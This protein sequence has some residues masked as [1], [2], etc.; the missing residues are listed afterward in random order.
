[1]EG[2]SSVSIVLVEPTHPGNIGAAARAM[3]NM[4]LTRLRLVRPAAF[5]S[6]EATALAAGARDVLAATTVHDDL[7]SALAGT[8]WVIATTARPRERSVPAR[9]MELACREAI[10]QATNGREVAVVFGREAHG[11]SNAEL[12]RCDLLTHI[13]TA[14]DFSSLNLA[15]AVQVLAYELCRQARQAGD[16]PAS[17]TV[18][19][20]LPAGGEVARGLAQH[21]EQVVR[22][23]GYENPQAPERTHRRLRSLLSR[24]R[25]TESDVQFLR[26]L[27]AAVQKAVRLRR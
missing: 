21:L 26:G 1:M 10:G 15:Q 13:P 25:P 27:L 9:D 20:E 17:D 24:M 4:G 5:P 7:E 23:V 6:A 8:G 3:R 14:A 11:L 18:G 19:A 16:D 12:D 22:E 2:L